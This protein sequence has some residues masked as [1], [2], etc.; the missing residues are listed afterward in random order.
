[1]ENEEPKSRLDEVEKN[2]YRRDTPPPVPPRTELRGKN[3]DVRNDWA[4]RDGDY[5][6]NG[7]NGN[8]FL[9]KVLLLAVFIFVVTLG[10]AAFVLYRG[11]NQISGS[12]I[13]FEIKGPVAVKAGDETVLQVLIGNRNVSNLEDVKLIVEYPT[14]TKTASSTKVSLNR[15]IDN[16]G[17][18]DSGE[19]I[20]K[21]FKSALFGAEGAE[22]EIKAKIEYKVTGSNALYTKETETF[23]IISSPS[24]NL[25]LKAIPEIVSGQNFKLEITVLPRAKQTEDKTLLVLDYPT[26]FTFSSASI[27]P[28]YRDN[29]WLFD[30]LTPGEEKTLVVEGTLSGNEND[31]KS[32]VATIGAQDPI[33]EDTIIFPYNRASHELKIKAPYVS[34]GLELDSDKGLTH[35]A[36]GGKNIELN[37]NWQNNLDTTLT[38]AI[39]RLELNGEAL[40]K[41]AVMPGTGLFRT[42]DNSIT[43]N[44]STVPGLGSIKP[45]A[46]GYV[47]LRLATKD[48]ATSE[49][50]ALRNPNITVKAILVANRTA[51]GFQGEEI[52]A[53]KMSEIKL[54]T[55]AKLNQKVLRA[56]GPFQNTGPMPPK[57]EQESTFTAVWTVTNSSNIIRDGLVKTVL[58]PQIEWKNIS[59]PATEELAFNPVSRELVWKLGRVLPGAPREVVF[60]LGLVPALNQVGIAPVIIGQAKFSGFDT[61]AETVI[62]SGMADINTKNIS[63]VGYNALLG[64]VER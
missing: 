54:R 18:I 36:D 44:K 28:S 51:N 12:N 61:F 21:T 56:E 31:N 39:L 23:I 32:F 26:G 63:D 27:K 48:L 38:D 4:T 34:L 6:I 40:N 43:W 37:I 22:K 9:A 20:N 16:L 57:V 25:A 7:G 19:V 17:T 15:V 53:E 30:S 13:D 41:N 24:I 8:S 58:P 47:N 11:G 5:N 46:T 62:E 10:I 60:N 55:V 2:L 49:G 29:A 59:K 50:A 45:G 1:M 33:G 52:R 64:N 3:F 42:N 14:D 35:I